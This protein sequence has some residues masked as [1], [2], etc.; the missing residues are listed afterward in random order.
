[1]DALAQSWPRGLCK[2]AF[3]PSEPSRT[4]TVQDQG[5]QGAD[6]ARG[7]I[8]AHSDL[9]PRADAPRDSPSL[10]DSSEEGSTDSEM[11]HLVAGTCFCALL[12][13]RDPSF[14]LSGVRMGVVCC[15]QMVTTDAS[16]SGWGAVFEERPAY[17][18]W[19]GKY[20]VWYI[21][22]LELRAVHLA[23]THFLPFLTNSHVIVRTDNMAVV[24]H[25]NRLGGSRARTLNRHARQLLLWAQ[26]TFLSLRAVHVPGVLNLAVDFLSRQKLRSGE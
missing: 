24:P 15:C 4:D 8:L 5:G 16:L 10:A 17:G 7:A 3:S 18:V 21:N 26:E 13:W 11:G 6:P 2:Y 14:L 20:L 25:I 23:L 9:V 22:V 12:V 1:M 19:S